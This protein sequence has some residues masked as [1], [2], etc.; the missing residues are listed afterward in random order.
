MTDEARQEFES[1]YRE[2]FERCFHNHPNNGMRKRALQVLRF[3]TISSTPL[4][5]E[6]EDW[7]EGIIFIANQGRMSLGFPGL[8]NS[9]FQKLYG[10]SIETVRK[11]A[12]EIDE[13]V[14]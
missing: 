1:A 12:A 8:L 13:L 10:V 2:R 14:L 6:L 7:A 4:P 5:G 3:L 9:E 11:R